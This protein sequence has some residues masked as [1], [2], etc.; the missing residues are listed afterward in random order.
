MA[1]AGAL[2]ARLADVDALIAA[3]PPSDADGAARRYLAV[4]RDELPRW[5]A[6]VAAWA[7]GA[8]AF[9]AVYPE[10]FA[11]FE[12][13][14]EASAAFRAAMP[15]EPPAP[16]GSFEAARQ[17]C[18]AGTA[19]AATAAR[20]V[21]LDE[22]EVEAPAP[23]AR[24]RFIQP[25]AGMLRELGLRCVRLAADALEHAELPMHGAAKDLIALGLHLVDE[26]DRRAA[27]YG[28]YVTVFGNYAQVVA[29]A[30][31]DGMRRRR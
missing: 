12:R 5:T 6:G 4:V 22:V 19:V 8:E 9:G 7:A 26:E 29:Y 20:A 21:P 28:A 30:V 11:S 14:G 15:P 31:R 2:D 17:A 3:A 10:L 23:A 24:S 13:F 25:R 18:L 27:V 1:D 16:A